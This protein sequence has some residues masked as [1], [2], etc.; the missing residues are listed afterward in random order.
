MENYQ[1][2][3]ERA[4]L[5]S[6]FFNPT[7][8]EDVGA[9]LKAD[10]FFYPAHRLIYESMSE[11]YRQEIPIDAEFVRKKLTDNKSFDEQ[12]LSD[13]IAT[14]PFA[15]IASYVTEIKDSSIKRELNRLASSIR[16]HTLESDKKSSEIL[17]SLHAELYKITQESSTKDFKHSKEAILEMLD[18]I[19]ELKA[20]GNTKLIGVDTGFKELNNLTTGLNKG[21]LIIVAARPAM[22]KTAFVLNIAQKALD[23]GVG[24]A[25]F[26]LE[27]PADQLLLRM[28]SAKT[29]LPLQDI[30]VGNLEDAEWERMISATDDMARKPLFIDDGGNLNIHQLRAKLRKLKSKHPEVGLAVIDYL[31][32]MTSGVM[33]ERHLEISEISRGLKLLA[34]ELEMPI[35]ALSQLNR[36]LE[37]RSDK[38]PMLSDLRESG[39][40][41]QDADIILFVFREAVYRMKD[42]K[43]KEEAAKKEGKQYRSDFS[44]KNEEEAE[45]IIGKH[46]NGPIGTVHL[47]FQKHCTR[48]VDKGSGEVEILYTTGSFDTKEAKIDMPKI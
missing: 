24:V 26:S 7:S 17:D 5:S 39:A 37:A 8:F 10:D 25:I 20:R 11:L 36:S 16:D 9:L 27:M 43:E 29:S 4:V 28:T 13:I 14:S 21:D 42:E 48:F 19:R 41:E 38:R 6:I 2:T 35:I 15:N 1:V 44:L 22:G 45:I 3:I 30:R 18:N 34:R 12:E 32:L 40:I 31:Q 46:R 33:K 23:T 47:M